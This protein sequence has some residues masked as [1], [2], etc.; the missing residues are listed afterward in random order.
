MTVCNQIS[1]RKIHKH[2]KDRGRS[3]IGAANPFDT[4][5]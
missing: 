3:D 4:S 1:A 2:K 5:H